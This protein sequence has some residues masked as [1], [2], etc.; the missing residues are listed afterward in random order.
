VDLTVHDL[1]QTSLNRT[2]LSNCRRP[3][4]I[5]G[6][7]LRYIDHRGLFILRDHARR[8]GTEVV[9]RTSNPGPSRLIDVLELEGIVM[10]AA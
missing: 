1:F 8:L 5:D 3:V 4:V 10:E 2:E 9:L 7:D 6:R